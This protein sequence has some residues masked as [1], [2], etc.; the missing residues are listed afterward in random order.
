MN[1]L[2]LFD[3]DETLVEGVAGHKKVFSAAFKKVYGV[4]TTID[5]VSYSGMTDPQ[6]VLEVLRKNGLSDQ[7]IISKMEDCLKAMVASFK[8]IVGSDKIT[9]LPGVK[10]LLEEF[11]KRGILLGLVTGNLEP[12]AISKLNKVGLSAYFKVGGFGSDD[13]HRVNLIKLAIKRAREE[14]S[15][16][17]N[18]NVFLF[19]DSVKDIEAG[20]EA[21]V[22]T[23]GVATGIYSEEQLK[24]AGA[25]FAFENLEDTGKVL[26]RLLKNE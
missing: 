19:G 23:V 24:A 17:S 8:E 10:K 12:I 4:E 16:E 7:V 20:K 22:K 5:V 18:N 21:E 2:V 11:K 25:D 26:D 1:R 9:I 15:F 13:I 14:L 3:I 6:V